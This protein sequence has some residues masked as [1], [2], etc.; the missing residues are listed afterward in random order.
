MF[1]STFGHQMNQNGHVIAVFM[2]LVAAFNVSTILSMQ[3]SF[4]YI[5]QGTSHKVQ[6]ILTNF[7]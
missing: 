2:Y 5:L 3:K 7:D 4:D 6:T 1:G